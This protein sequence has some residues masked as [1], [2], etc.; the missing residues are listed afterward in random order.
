MVSYSSL[1]IFS[2]TFLIFSKLS[3]TIPTLFSIIKFA[4]AA[5]RYVITGIPAAIYKENL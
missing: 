5:L 3:T 1:E 2:I 4:I